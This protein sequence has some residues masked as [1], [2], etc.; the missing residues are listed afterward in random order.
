MH[1]GIHTH[2]HTNRGNV[3]EQTYPRKPLATQLALSI[4]PP[5][6]LRVTTGPTNPKPHSPHQQTNLLPRVL[7]PPDQSTDP[8]LSLS[9]SSTNLRFS[10]TTM[11]SRAHSRS[12]SHP[13]PNLR[14]CLALG[15]GIGPR[16]SAGAR[17]PT[18]TTLAHTIGGMPL[19]SGP[20]TAN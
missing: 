3:R 17:R 4:P 13:F 18:A 5:H 16:R 7:S 9:H 2:A 15:P 12:L 14:L 1:I 6:A 20:A 10:L 19:P 8:L 11:H